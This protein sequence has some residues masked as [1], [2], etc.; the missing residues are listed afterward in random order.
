ML[1]NEIPEGNWGSAGMIFR[2][3]D[4][5]SYILKGVPRQID[6]Q[7]VGEEFALEGAGNEQP[8]TSS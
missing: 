1:I 6:E 7:D 3:P 4:I 5:A 8:V 2:F